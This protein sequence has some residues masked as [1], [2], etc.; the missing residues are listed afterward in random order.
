[1]RNQE[2]ERIGG[3]AFESVGALLMF[4]LTKPVKMPPRGS[5]YPCDAVLGRIARETSPRCII[6]T[7]KPIWG[8]N[9]VGV[10]LGLFDS[11]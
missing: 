2:I 10:A 5:R 8:E 6:D 9:V 7:D 1:M 11:V 3:Q 4:G